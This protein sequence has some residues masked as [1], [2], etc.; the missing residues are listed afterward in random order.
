MRVL[1]VDLATEPRETLACWL[2]FANGRAEAEIVAARL[3]DPT[4]VELLK[5]AD[6]AA[7]DSPFG[8][9]EPFFR[10]LA[11]WRTEG[12]FPSGSREPLRL[13]ATDLVV[14]REALAPF[15]VSADKL[16]ALAM[17]CAMLLTTLAD[18]TDAPID[19]V[20]GNVIECYPSAALYR[21]GFSRADLRG[22][23]TDPQVR[24]RLLDSITLRAQWLQLEPPLAEVLVEVGHAFDA[25]ISA[26]VARAAAVGLTEQPPA[27]LASLAAMEGWIHLPLHG[28]LQQLGEP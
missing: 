23:K 21:F 22:A 17:R 6:R 27:E 20:N 28:S 15:S 14:K 13:R 7:I 25:F 8:W 5:V 1:G 18:Q 12:T 4:L 24:A 10:A 16:G 2:S 19:R 9:P 3:D 26:L 11:R